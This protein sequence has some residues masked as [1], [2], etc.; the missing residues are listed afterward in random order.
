M[1]SLGVE[2]LACSHS[3][4][5]S[6]W[7]NMWLLSHPHAT[8]HRLK[9]K[10]TFTNWAQ[11]HHFTFVELSLESQGSDQC[12]AH[13]SKNILFSLIILEGILSLCFLLEHWF[14]AVFT[15]LLVTYYKLAS[16]SSPPSIRTQLPFPLL[17]ITDKIRLNEVKIKQFWEETEWKYFHNEKWSISVLS[18]LWVMVM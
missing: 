8:T 16:A 1:F 14:A 18:H 3:W 11:M 6:P 7:R 5:E 13:F 15:P 17:V 12:W 4:A 9:L 10:E 2:V